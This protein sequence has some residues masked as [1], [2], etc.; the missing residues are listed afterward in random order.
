MVAAGAAADNLEGFI[1]YTGRVKAQLIDSNSDLSTQAVHNMLG[2]VPF[3]S[4]E[5]DPGDGE[6]SGDCTTDNCRLVAWSDE[7][8]EGISGYA[9]AGHFKAWTEAQ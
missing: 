9:T 2:G 1:P 6:G 8:L 5:D 3:G 4:T 7:G